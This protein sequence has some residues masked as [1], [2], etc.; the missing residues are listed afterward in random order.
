MRHLTTEGATFRTPHGTLKRVTPKGCPPKGFRI[1]LVTDDG[2]PR[3]DPD[4]HVFGIDMHSLDEYAAT[5]AC[6]PTQDEREVL[7][8]MAFSLEQHAQGN[9]DRVADLPPGEARDYALAELERKR[10]WAEP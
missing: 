3:R 7:A 5:I 4:G 10:L 6:H 8:S 1:T 2:L 9:S